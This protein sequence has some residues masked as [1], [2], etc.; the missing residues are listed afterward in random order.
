MR[1]QT[2]QALISQHL[3]ES[4]AIE[5]MQ[6]RSLQTWRISDIVNMTSSNQHVAITAVLGEQYPR[7]PFSLNT[8]PAH[9]MPAPGFGF[10]KPQLRKLTSSPWI[11]HTNYSTSRDRTTKRGPSSPSD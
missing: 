7:K 4:R 10:S 3:D 2:G 8:Y 5:L 9:M 11:D 1:H 6:P